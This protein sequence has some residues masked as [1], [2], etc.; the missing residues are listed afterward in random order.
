[1][2]ENVK[3]IHRIV[4]SMMLYENIRDDLDKNDMLRPAAKDSDIIWQQMT[5]GNFGEFLESTSLYMKAYSEY[6]AYDEKKICD[7]IDNCYLKIDQ[8]E[9]SSKVNEELKSKEKEIKEKLIEHDKQMYISCWYSS[10]DLSDVV[11]N[12][13]T[14]NSGIAVGTTVKK[15]TE[16]IEETLEKNKN[17]NC[18]AGNIQYI[19]SNMRKES[20]FEPTQ[21]IA[22]IFLKGIQFKA[23]NEFRICLQTDKCEEPK[24]NGEDAN[25]E[26]EG[27]HHK[28]FTHIEKSI[29]EDDIFKKIE[30]A[31]YEIKKCEEKL[32]TNHISLNISL[33]IDLSDLITYIAV[34]DDGIFSR[35]TNPDLEV[36]DVLKS[37]LNKKLEKLEL[38]V[39]EPSEI[40]KQHESGFIVFEVVSKEG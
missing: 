3:S 11:F 7:Y 19:S 35:L 1:M 15:L 37:I 34:K 29:N 32:K 22:P 18:F 36:K 2:K 27:V 23:D 8:Q 30:D 4:P 5:W 14:G 10:K 20:L 9:N 31:D 28:H 39:K 40:A 25:K 33:K 16:C 17:Y 21:V 26:R 24:F 6:N 38:K 12:Q 13:Y